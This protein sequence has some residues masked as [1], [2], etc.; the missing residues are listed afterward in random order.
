MISRWYP[1]VACIVLA[2][3]PV[4]K[5]AEFGPAGTITFRCTNPSSSANW[6]IEIDF[7]HHV[8]DSYPAKISDREIAWHNN[9]D[10]GNYSLDPTTG[11]LTVSRASSTGG[12]MIFNVCV[13]GR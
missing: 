9:D 2:L 6:N 8:A 7:D 4:A 10:A 11:R 3:T 13:A 5:S 1:L 12:Y